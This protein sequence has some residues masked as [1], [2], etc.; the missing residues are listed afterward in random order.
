[1]HKS[2]S[3]MGVNKLYLYDNTIYNNK[4][5]GELSIKQVKKRNYLLL[6]VEFAKTNH[7][8]QLKWQD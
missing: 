1:M 3:L 6:T 2:L 8:Y 5:Y 4:Y 7:K